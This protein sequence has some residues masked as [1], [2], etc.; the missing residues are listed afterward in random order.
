MEKELRSKIIE[1]FEYR[2]L[3]NIIKLGNDGVFDES[4]YEGL[5]QLQ[6]DIYYLDHVLETNWEV[7]MDE[8]DEKW[9][10]IHGSLRN[11]GVDESDVDAYCAHIYKYQKHEL[12]IRQAR[13]PMR[14]SMEYFYFYKSCDVK[15]M[16]RLIYDRYPSLHKLCKLS[17]WRLFDLVTEIDDDVEDVYEDMTTINGNRFLLSL[18]KLG[19]K[20]TNEIFSDYLQELLGRAKALDESP[21]G[22]KKRTLDKYKETFKLFKDR[23]QKV[24]TAELLKAEIAGYIM[25]RR[26]AV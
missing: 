20:E 4:F 13:Y 12:E 9:K 10:A 8:V 5:I 7:D 26:V 19:N 22:H 23:L 15:L 3:P 18:L 6:A 11:L 25:D 24:S 17:E 14:L 2:D 16:R 21:L 1:L